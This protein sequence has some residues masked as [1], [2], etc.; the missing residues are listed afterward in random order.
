MRIYIGKVPDMSHEI[1]EVLAKS[2]AIEVLPDEIKEVEEDIASVLRE[3]IRLEKE[4]TEKARDIISYRNLDFTYLSR[5]KNDL[6]KEKG[7]GIGDE[8][9][10]YLVEQIIEMF[11]YSSHVEEIYAQ[12]HE[13]VRALVPIIKKYMVIEEELDQEVKKRIKNLQEGTSTWE[14]QYKK[15][16]EDLKKAKKLIE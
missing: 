4:I 16:M 8:V 3:Y 7:I 12:D 10:K 6:L 13:I 9:I 11:F 5:I 2:G 15:H 1:V 14:I